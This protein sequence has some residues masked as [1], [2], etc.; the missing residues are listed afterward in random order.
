MPE[1]SRAINTEQPVGKAAPVA[2]HGVVLYNNSD[3]YPD[4]FRLFININEIHIFFYNNS[5]N[6]TLSVH[7]RCFKLGYLF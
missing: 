7:F 2:I 4:L 1:Y 5:C 6:G 3:D